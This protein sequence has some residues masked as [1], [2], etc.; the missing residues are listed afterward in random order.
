MIVET[1]GDH[2]DADGCSLEARHD[3]LVA[4]E[5]VDVTSIADVPLRGLPTVA[6]R[7][8]CLAD[9]SLASRCAPSAATPRSGRST[10]AAGARNP[11]SRARSPRLSASRSRV[12]RASTSR[13]AGST[14]ETTTPT[15]APISVSTARRQA[16]LSALDDAAVSTTRP[17]IGTCRAAAAGSRSTSSATPSD[18]AT[19]M[20]T[21]SAVP[22][23]GRRRSPR[24]GG[25]RAPPR[26]CAGSP[27][28]PTTA[29]RPGPPRWP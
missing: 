16:E 29:P 10:R 5:Q 23:P 20:A 26:R 3:L 7:L 19:S 27:C 8:G 9:E 15:A 17:L 14:S 18:T 2:R 22:A 21:V 6:D 13:D 28:A 1:A 4:T 24:R 12:W 11:S 25:R